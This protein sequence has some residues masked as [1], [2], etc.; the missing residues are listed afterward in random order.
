MRQSLNQT[1][2]GTKEYMAPRIVCDRGQILRVPLVQNF[3]PEADRRRQSPTALETSTFGFTLVELLV[4]IGLFAVIILV[5]MPSVSKLGDSRAV[6]PAEELAALLTSAA[7]N[8]R[9]GANASARGLYLPYD[10]ATRLTDEVI[11]FSGDS[12]ALR[13]AV[14]DIVFDFD[15]GTTFDA[16]LLSGA[17]PSSGD[18]HEAVFS[19]LTGETSQYGT[20]TLTFRGETRIID[21]SPSGFITTN[22]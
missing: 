11:L 14:E 9:H 21:V 22:P 8:A 5:T 12:Y 19:A 3:P 7:R 2:H 15:E 18:D 6:E 1:T 20:I 13:D 16:V 10:N 4:S 17:V